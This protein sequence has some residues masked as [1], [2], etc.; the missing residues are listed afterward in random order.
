MILHLSM[1]GVYKKKVI[2]LYT[3]FKSPC[4]R[5]TDNNNIML[6]LYYIGTID[7]THSARART[8]AGFSGLASTSPH[9]CKYQVTRKYQV[10]P[11]L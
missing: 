10:P 7:N 9:T 8:K 5:R 6:I 1:Q 4:D 2:Q 3:R 11:K